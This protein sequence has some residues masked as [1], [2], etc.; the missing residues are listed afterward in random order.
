MFLTVLPGNQKLP[1]AIVLVTDADYKT[2]SRKRYSF[3]WKLEKTKQVY[4]L[5]VKGEQDILGLISLAFIDEEQRIAINLLSVAIEHIG[6][7]KQ[8]DRI[9]GN[10]LAFSARLAIKKYGAFAA[11]SLIPKTLLGQYYMD[12]YGFEQAGLSLFMEGRKL[13]KLLKEYDYD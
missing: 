7:S 8:L 10:L 1:V 4:K 5:T 2:I 13:I 9:A 12:K 3:N 6:K 11:I